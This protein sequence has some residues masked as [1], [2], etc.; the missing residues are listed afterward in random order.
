MM[1]TR[2]ISIIFSVVV[3]VT[4][5]T[6]WGGSDVSAGGGHK[7]KDPIWTD[8]GYVAGTLMDLQTYSAESVYTQTGMDLG[9]ITVGELGNE[10]RIYREGLQAH[11]TGS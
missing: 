2:H 7:L 4:V 11:N 3:F 10:I 9:D 8:A 5:F 6:V 1:R